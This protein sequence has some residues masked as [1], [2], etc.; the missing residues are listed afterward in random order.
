MLS[1][2]RIKAVE[3]GEDKLG[4]PVPALYHVKVPPRHNAVFEVNIHSKL[5]GTQVITGNKHL[6]GKHPNMYHH[7]ISIVTESD[8]KA[9]P[10]MAIMNL[11]QVKTLHLAKG[12]VVGFARPESPDV[13]Y[14]VTTNELNIE[15]TS[16][17][18]PRNWIPQQKC[19]ECSE[20][21]QDSRMET[22]S[23]ETNAVNTSRKGMT[24][25]FQEST[26]EYGEDSQKS[27]IRN[28]ITRDDFP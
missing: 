28:S 9:F 23:T 21:S 2:N 12:E 10:L 16:D 1:L 18:V 11:D 14:I 7:A 19:S 22:E 8:S 13:M 25:T 15:E 4:I 20:S 24:M 6:L 27:R 26:C 3:V 5:Q 17:I